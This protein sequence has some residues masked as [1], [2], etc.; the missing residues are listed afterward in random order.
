MLT[1]TEEKG[2]ERKREN[3]IKKGKRIKEK[4]KRKKKAVWYLKSISFKIS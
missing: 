1:T 4:I 2:R 3:K